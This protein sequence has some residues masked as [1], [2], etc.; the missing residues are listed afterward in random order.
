M[1]FAR[2]AEEK[3]EDSLP[4]LLISGPRSEHGTSRIRGKSGN[5]SATTFSFGHKQKSGEDYRRCDK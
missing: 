4:G 5:H 2:V 1:A 3:Y